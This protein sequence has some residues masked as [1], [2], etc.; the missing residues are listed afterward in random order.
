MFYNMFLSLFPGNPTFE[1][2]L[3]L[4]VHYNKAIR[5]GILSH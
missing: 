5:T 3:I 2:S 1:D 4:R